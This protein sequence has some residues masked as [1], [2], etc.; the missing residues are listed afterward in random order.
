[1]TGRL[2]VAAVALAGITGATVLGW[3]FGD[4]TGFRRGFREGC[5]LERRNQLAQQH[6]R[7]IIAVPG[8]PQCE[9]RRTS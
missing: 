9:T 5:N 1:M 4:L 3:V 2:L 8:C 7:H 6:R